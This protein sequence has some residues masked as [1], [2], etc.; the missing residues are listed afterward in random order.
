MWFEFH[1]SK[2]TPNDLLSLFLGI[3]TEFVSKDVYFVMLLLREGKKSE[4]AM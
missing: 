3:C 2:K 1:K 4:L